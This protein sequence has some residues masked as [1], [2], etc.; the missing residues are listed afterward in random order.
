MKK[1]VLR[2]CIGCNIKKDKRE[3]IRLVINKQG[4]FFIDSSRK[5]EGRGTYIC[6]SLE[7]LE[8]ANKSKR[9]EKTFGIRIDEELYKDLRGVIL[10]NETDVMIEKKEKKLGGDI[11]G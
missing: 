10:R 8:K 4:D 3:L 1:I 6:N 11:N 9:L 7:C 5:A 2:T